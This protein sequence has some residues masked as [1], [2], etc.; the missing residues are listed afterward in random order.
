MNM[1][2]FPLSSSQLP[3]Q[4]FGFRRN[5]EVG[6]YTPLPFDDDDA[7]AGDGSGERRDILVESEFLP[8]DTDEE[9]RGGSDSLTEFDRGV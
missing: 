1:Y 2:V 5:S 4:G 8:E 9:K 3:N 7:D 6:T